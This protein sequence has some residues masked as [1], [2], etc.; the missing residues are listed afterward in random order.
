MPSDKCRRH[1]PS[2]TELG[3][4]ERAVSAENGS[5]ES[6]RASGLLNHCRS[7]AHAH[8]PDGQNTWAA[9]ILCLHSA[10]PGSIYL[11]GRLRT[12]VLI[13]VH[14]A[15][16]V[17]CVACMAREMA[18]PQRLYLIQS[19]HSSA[20]PLIFQ[21]NAALL[22]AAGPWKRQGRT[23]ARIEDPPALSRANC[24]L[25]TPAH[26]PMRLRVDAGA[27]ACKNVRVADGLEAFRR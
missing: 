20:H 14:C 15:V 21:P 16:R 4:R 9:K 3:Q 2:R 7:H 24:Q 25:S 23:G 13:F 27:F 22:A 11:S 19:N 1:F 5:S 10:H 8:Q 18:L 6:S 17:R 12:E 26:M